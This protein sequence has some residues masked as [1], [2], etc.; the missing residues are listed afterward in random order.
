MNMTLMTNDYLEYYLTLVGWVINNGIWAIIT[1]TGLFALPFLII[2]IREWLKVR[3]EGADEGNKGALS[4]ARIE[5]HIYVGYFVVMFCGIPAMSIGLDTL[6][7]DQSRATQCQVMVPNPSETG[8]GATFSSIAGQS[9]RVPV[10]WALM[11][12]L[13]KGVTNASIAAIPCGTDL[14]QMRMDLDAER[15]DN[16]L[17]AQ[18]V[19]DFTRDCFGYSRA[20][21]FMRQPD[22]GAVTAGQELSKHY[23]ALQDLNW[24]GSRYFLNTPGYYDTDY[25]R[26]PRASWPYDAERDVGMPQVTGGGGYPYCKQWWSD[27][28][29]GL[30][31]RLQAQ[32]DPD[33][34]SQFLGWANW[35]S[36]EE[37]TDGL[38]RQLVSPTNQIRGDVY[39]DYGGQI[40]HSVPNALGRAASIGGV[41]LGSLAYFPAMDAMRQALPMVVSFLKMALVICIPIVL[42]VS[43][44]NLSTAMTMSVV[45]FA[46]MF[47]DF[48][49]QLGRWIDS[50]INQAMY[51]VGSPNHTFNPL[52]GLDHASQDIILDFV[53]AAMFIILPMFWVTALGWAGIKAS[54]ALRGLSDG[55]KGVQN[56]GG[57][58]AKKATNSLM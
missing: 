30:R 38:I 11:H 42:V 25:S 40:G 27:R 45:F 31:D 48:W 10:W 22:L 28:G 12:T 44:Y 9:A 13:S 47:V 7:F 55:V 32:I 14:R 41:A 57:E 8:W 33:L 19:A 51:G 36:H 24:I 26:T 18:E 15:I 43:A 50:T 6:T 20:R 54:E 21:L 2:V 17:L 58:A 23:K 46:L 4:I 37:V 34:T 5:T 1:D 49:F 52:M 53:M 16:P 29:V 35:L 56:S 3:Q 39:T